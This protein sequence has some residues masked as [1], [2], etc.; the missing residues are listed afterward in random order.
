MTELQW[1]L[2]GDRRSGSAVVELALS[3]LGA[4]YATV[5]V[6]LASDAQRAADYRQVNPQQKL[7]SLVTPEGET[8]T[9]T[10]AILIYLS[11]RFTA[12]PLLPSPGTADRARALRWLLFIASELYPL[13]EIIDYPQRFVPEPLSVQAADAQRDHARSI[14]KRRWR[15]VENAVG[16]DPWFLPAGFSALDLYVAVVSRWAQLDDWRRANLPRVEAIA[17]A[18]AAR[19]DCEA[20]WARHFG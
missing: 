12:P 3:V 13:I 18:L 11:E 5:D 8:L 1:I 10:A 17:A 7:P 4:D 19:P 6:P 15:I 14:W 16:G 20:A 9:E 2:Y